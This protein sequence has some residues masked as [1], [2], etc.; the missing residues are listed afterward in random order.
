MQMEK[1]LQ[2][3]RNSMAGNPWV[4]GL[5]HEFEQGAGEASNLEIPT[6]P[7]KKSLLSPAKELETN[8]QCVHSN[9]SSPAEHHRKQ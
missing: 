5:P 9:S 6:H 2:D 4:L 1:G 7:D 3:P 8:R